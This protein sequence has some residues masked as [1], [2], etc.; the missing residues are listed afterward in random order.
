MKT[1]GHIGKYFML[2]QKVFSQ[3]EKKR[4]YYRQFIKEIQSLV[5]DSIGI[6][7]IISI[8]MGA[9]VTLQTAYNTENPF[10]PKYLI[11]LGC[12]DSIILEF[13]STI[14]ALILAGKVGSNIASELGTMKVTEQIDALEIMGV[15]SASYLIFPKIMATVIFNPL[16]TMISIIVGL[17][18]GWLAVVITGVVSASEF[19]YGVQYAFVPFYITYAL[20]KTVF[21]AFIIT[22]ISAYHGYY[23][24]GGSLEVG[25]ASTRAVVYSSI[26]ILLFNVILTQLLLS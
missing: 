20:I 4:I 18:G 9:M 12:R 15:N 22:S 10:L 24:S 11:G 7:V 8:F 3:P 26:V 16:L 1:I 14:I 19:I 5:I 6:V 21:F 13:S 2:L 25:K 23:V 17:F